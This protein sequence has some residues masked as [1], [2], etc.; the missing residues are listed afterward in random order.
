MNLA[1]RSIPV[2]LALAL[3]VAGCSSTTL[4]QSTPGK[5]KVYLDG[6]LVGET[7]YRHT[8]ARIV[9]SSMTVRLVKDGYDPLMCT[10]T[11]DEEIDVEAV[12]GGIFVAVPLLWCMRY[13]PVH[14]YEL[15]PESVEPVEKPVIQ[16]VQPKSGSK[17]SRLR[18]LKQLMDEKVITPDEFE[19]EKTK[20]LDGK[21]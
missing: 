5:A 13:Q 19:K 16:N 1:I 21:Q 14:A 11:K 8:D 2:F 20:V 17:A 10:I 6:T 18:E 12:V 4:I 7:P 3:L 15:K 9:G